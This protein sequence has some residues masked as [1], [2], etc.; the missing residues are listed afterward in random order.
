ML[1]GYDTFHKNIFRYFL[2][3]TNFDP[4]CMLRLMEK[5]L[6]AILRHKLICT[7]SL[8]NIDFLVN[9]LVVVRTVDVICTVYTIFFLEKL[10]ILKF[11]NAWKYFL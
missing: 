7:G 6:L 3:V 10:E 11:Y 4:D 9:I 8:Q 2:L 1:P 5:N